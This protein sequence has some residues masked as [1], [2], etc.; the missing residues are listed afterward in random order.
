MSMPD[1]RLE[2]NGELHAEKVQK[3][4]TPSATLPRNRGG[5]IENLLNPSRTSKNS[6]LPPQYSS[7]GVTSR[8]QALEFPALR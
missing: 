2:P 3:T 6:S 5:K 4:E 8:R 1:C 7:F